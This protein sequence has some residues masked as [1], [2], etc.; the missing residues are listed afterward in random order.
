MTSHQEE[1]VQQNQTTASDYQNNS[2]PELK[3]TVLPAVHTQKFVLEN[4]KQLRERIAKDIRDFDQKNLPEDLQTEIP[5]LAVLLQRIERLA[6]N[7]NQAKKLGALNSLVCS[8][9]VALSSLFQ[10]K[11]T[12]EF[13]RQIRLDVEQEVIGYEQPPVLR[14]FVSHFSYIWHTKSVRLSVIY[15]LFWS[16]V[17][18]FGGLFSLALIQYTIYSSK[19]NAEIA[20]KST[21]G[22]TDGNDEK[23]KILENLYAQ[24]AEANSD[25]E[26]F[27]DQIDK[28]NKKV[29]E[30]S[31][32]LYQVVTSAPFAKDVKNEKIAELKKNDKIAELKKNIAQTNKS[33]TQL[34]ERQKIA[35]IRGQNSFLQITSVDSFSKTLNQ[36]LWVAAAGTLGS[37]V[38]ILIRVIGKSYDQEAY[39]D[40]LTPIFIGFFKPVIGASFGVLFLA[41]IKA[42]V[43]STPLI[44]D[45]SKPA[46]SELTVRTSDNPETKAG[47]F[48]FS[49]GF[50]V[51]FSERLAKDTI[52]KLEGSSSASKEEGKG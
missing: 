46:S 38:S 43:V 17:I 18:M 10:K 3:V 25:V 12:K 19:A 2:R 9:E 50:I 13:T 11:L 20:K 41:F 42:G 52:S 40:R 5:K 24:L 35:L 15:G 7:T 33:L 31:T 32:E 22:K 21:D 23:N 4:I 36:I 47:F 45:M 26:K 29:E 1:T 14:L 48:L 44:P 37:I 39:Y 6:L 8:L 27:D 51:G 34:E 30:L 28:Q 16:F 49:V